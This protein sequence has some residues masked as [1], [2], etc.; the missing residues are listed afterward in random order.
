MSEL[1]S[2]L[3]QLGIDLV[4]LLTILARLSAPWW[5]A[6]VWA[7]LWL[8][9]VDWRKL[10]PRLAEGAWAPL[11][12]IGV[13]VALMWTSLA[14]EPWA[15]G[16]VAL[17]SFWW[18]LLAVAALIGSALFLGWLQGV[19]QWLPPEVAIEAP[20]AA[21]HGHDHGHG[22]AHGGHGEAHSPAH[23][24]HGHSAH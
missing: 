2:I 10:W 20:A 5:P 7:A 4:N 8:W 17:V 6:L 3:Q 23:D 12:L 22:E 18:H 11:T 9:A 15:I 16:N 21:G 13:M 14:P 24:S 1:S 19:M